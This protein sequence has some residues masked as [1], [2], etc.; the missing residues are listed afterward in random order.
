MGSSIELSEFNHLLENDEFKSYYDAGAKNIFIESGTLRGVTSVR[1]GPYYDLLHTIEISVGL[2]FSFLCKLEEYRRKNNPLGE[3][4][5]AHLGDTRNVL[6]KILS[7]EH[8]KENNATF[9]L[10]AHAKS[11]KGADRSG[12]SG[13]R[14]KDKRVRKA[15]RELVK[16]NPGIRHWPVSSFMVAVEDTINTRKQGLSIPLVGDDRNKNKVPLIKELELIKKLRNDKH[17]IIIIDDVRLFGEKRKGVNWEKITKEKIFNVLG[18][19]TF[20]FEHNDRLIILT[21][22]N[23]EH[24]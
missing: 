7:Y 13:I 18:K 8:T 21:N 11:V 6:K 3:K 20:S 23:G 19:N 9:F 5:I 4:I 24:S 10:D 1:M 14:L 15:W 2:H 16:K 17:D 12:I 22:W